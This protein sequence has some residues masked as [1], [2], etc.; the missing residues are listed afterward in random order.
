MT[1]EELDGF[2]ELAESLQQHTLE[3][4]EIY[5]AAIDRI[6][7][8]KV[9]D[10]KEIEYVLDHLVS[11]CHDDKMLMLYKKLCRYYYEINP[12]ATF[13]HINIYLDMWDMEE[14]DEEI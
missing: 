9:Q 10:E 14:T 13:E 8:N 1:E 3:A 7:S 12:T 5:K 4:F 6:Y 11:Y 2:K